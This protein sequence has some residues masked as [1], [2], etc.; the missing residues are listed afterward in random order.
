MK[1]RVARYNLNKYSPGEC[2]SGSTCVR[3]HR[4]QA[5]IAMVGLEGP[6]QIERRSSVTRNLSSS[7][8]RVIF[9]VGADPDPHHIVI[10]FDPDGTIVQANA[11][12]PV[13]TNLLKVKGRVKGV[14]QHVFVT[15]IGKLTDFDG[16]VSIPLPEPRCGPM[17]QRSTHLPSLKSRRASSLKKSNRPAAASASNCLSQTSASYSANHALN[18]ASSSVPSCLTAC[19][20]SITLLMLI[21]SPRLCECNPVYCTASHSIGANTCP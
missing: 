12:G 17:S 9:G 21:R 11:N 10:R 7:E 6:S 19:S 1:G 13:F 16:K 20:I 5:C 14:L 3:P 2:S 15:A 8:E 18:M 4:T